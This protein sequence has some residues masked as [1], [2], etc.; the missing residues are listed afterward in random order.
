MDQP[1]IRVGA[2]EA[3]ALI[4][5][6]WLERGEGE[7][8]LGDVV[9]HPHQCEAVE[10]LRVLLAEHGGALLADEVGL[11]KTYVAL[12]LAADV[13]RRLV[14]APAALRAMW[15]RASHAAAV[16]VTLVTHEA[17]SVGAAPVGRPDLVIVDEAHHARNP[18]TRR[19]RQLERLCDGARVLLLTATP[20]HNSPRDLIALLALFLGGAARAADAG[21]LAAFVVRRGHDAARDHLTLP[22]VGAT[23]WL[24]I[25][26]TEV[27]ERIRALPPPVPLAD[28]AG[29]G[30]LV[31]HS[32][33]RQWASSNGALVGA[34][35]RRLLRAAALEEALRAGRLP[36]RREMLDWIVGDDAVQLG[37]PE[38]LAVA[39]GD[40]AMLSAVLAHAAAVRALRDAVRSDERVD[41][42]RARIVR[43]VRRRHAGAKVIAFS[44]Y[45]DTVT[46][47]FRQ[48]RSDGG[49]A[50]LTARGALVAGGPLTRA[51]AIARFAPVASG[52]RAPSRAERIDL[53]LATDLLSEGVN[54]QDASV[55]IHLDLPWTAARLEQRVGRVARIGSVAT[56]VSVY[57]LAPPAD[58]EHHLAV[59][60][61]LWRKDHGARVTVGSSSASLPWSRGRAPPQES[62]VHHME[63]LRRC[64]T[65]WVAAPRPDATP[66]VPGTA[67]AS[68]SVRSVATGFLALWDDGH[69]TRLLAA[70]GDAI[71]DHPSLLLDAARRAGGAD[72]VLA[73]G[74]VYDAVARAQS[75]LEAH[76]AARDAGVRDTTPPTSRRAV[77]HRIAAIVGRAP[78]QDRLRLGQLAAAARSSMHA[79]CGSSAER[80]LSEL[81][82]TA[83]PDEAWL[84]AVAAF[85]S[86]HDAGRG[87]PASASFRLLALI[88]LGER[89]AE[90]ER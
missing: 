32:L 37:F 18:A 54:L 43:A 48:L 10:R 12:A 74:A 44:T 24:T 1:L 4:A 70:S 25:P 58:A 49:V 60:A 55:V 73:P 29:A 63:S 52:V 21:S 67:P 75:W 33:L 38:L 9:L 41:R 14:V 84:R 86:A 46:A 87:V 26:G 59:E 35:A 64:I 69:R 57:A 15:Q 30:A 81:A 51:D 89:H 47:L 77:A 53:L 2:A 42:W 13:P 22:L 76:E 19:Y 8:R 17:L 27:A 66:V 83:M 71:G 40:E 7:R 23:R 72:T 90:S 88:V 82:R 36:S 85:A 5:A 39:P 79:R 28:G 56:A 62:A 34:C 68:A 11:G 50:A 16:P 45:A 61:L 20:I 80:V 3:R 6:R 31:A 65:A 78:R